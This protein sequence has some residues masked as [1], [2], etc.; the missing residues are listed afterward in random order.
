MERP[1]S[2]NMYVVQNEN[3]P[4]RVRSDERQIENKISSALIRVHRR[5]FEFLASKGEII[6][7]Y[8]GLDLGQRRDFS[9]IAV[10]Q[11][12]EHMAAWS[13]NPSCSLFVRHLER[14]ELGLS[15]TK[16]AHRVCEIMQNPTMAGQSRLVVDV[17]GVGAPV[18][19]L[20]RHA[21]IGGRTTAVTITA[22]DQAHGGNERW[23]V[24]KKDLLMGL[25]ILLEANQ[26]II[27]SNLK[28]AGT[29]LRELETMRLAGRSQSA[30]P[31]PDDLSGPG[32]SLLASQTPPH[33]LRHLPPPRNLNRNTNEKEQTTMIMTYLTSRPDPVRVTKP[34]D[35]I[36]VKGQILE[37]EKT[38]AEVLAQSSLP[39]GAYDSIDD[40]DPV[41]RAHCRL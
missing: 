3:Q 34:N 18:M 29:L 19:D 32:P 37:G 28:D 6:M 33:R 2:N 24:P 26:L 27:S 7:Y 9:T 23:S 41:L 25:E 15:Y 5:P 30:E 22:G 1:R 17:T 31:E 16:V 40:Y 12:Q 11:R 14:M 38:L 21:G 20:L 4:P 35:P 39:T 36:Q 8:I 10:I 13:P